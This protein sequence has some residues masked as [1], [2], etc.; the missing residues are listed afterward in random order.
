MACEMYVFEMA[1]YRPHTTNSTNDMR[2]IER[3][4]YAAESAMKP[5]T[6][7]KSYPNVQFCCLNAHTQI[8]QIRVATTKE[9]NERLNW[10][11]NKLSEMEN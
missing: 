10:Q 2:K 3:N 5:W 7:K 8:H 6:K 4:E 11:W 9:A 1:N